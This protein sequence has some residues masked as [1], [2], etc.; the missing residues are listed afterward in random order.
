MYDK[1]THTNVWKKRIQMY[2]KNTHTNVWQ[3]HAYKCMTKTCIQ[4]RI[5]MYDNNTHINVWKKPRI[6]TLIQMYGKNTYK[7]IKKT[8]TRMYG[9]KTSYT[10]AVGSQLQR[11]GSMGVQFLSQGHLSCDKEV[12]CHPSGCWDNHT[13]H[14]ATAAQNTNIQ[15][16]EKNTHINTHTNIWKKHAYKYAYKCMTKTR[17]QMYE[18]K[19]AYQC[20]RKTCIQTRVQMCDKNKHTNTYTNVWQKQAYKY[21]YKC[22]KKNA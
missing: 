5:Q 2:D 13:H 9:K 20:M 18:K 14:W 11:P 19:Q 4:N 10:G 17:M 22:M 21:V 1:N 16:Y 12:N 8:R 6:Q 7:C 3:K 15:M